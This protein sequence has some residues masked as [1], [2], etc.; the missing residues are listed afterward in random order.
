[1]FTS[2]NL[3]LAVGHRWIEEERLSSVCVRVIGHWEIVGQYP[4]SCVE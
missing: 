3:T 4:L 1:M 2:Q